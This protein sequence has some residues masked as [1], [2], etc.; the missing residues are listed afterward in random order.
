MVG[1][2]DSLFRADL[3]MMYSE[4]TSKYRTLVVAK[5][6]SRISFFYLI[7]FYCLLQYSSVKHHRETQLNTV[8]KTHR[9]D[10]YCGNFS[11]IGRVR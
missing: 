8:K 11:T 2:D 4:E 5:I 3:N 1:L 10:K 9:I 6:L 7:V